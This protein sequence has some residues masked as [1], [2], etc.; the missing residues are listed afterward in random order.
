MEEPWTQAAQSG[1]Q[2]LAGQGVSSAKIVWRRH[3]FSSRLPGFCWSHWRWRLNNFPLHFLLKVRR[4]SFF[5]STEDKLWAPCI[6]TSSVTVPE[7]CWPIRL[8]AIAR[9]GSG[10]NFPGLIE[11]LQLHFCVALFICRVLFWGLVG[12]FLR[13][14]NFTFIF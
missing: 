7:A 1:I 5:Q 10:G 13:S 11:K 14:F 4:L 9:L 12:F 3:C 2:L 8:N 6:G